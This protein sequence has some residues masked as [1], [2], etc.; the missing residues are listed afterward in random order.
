M[1][2]NN[3]KK[4]AGITLW[5]VA[6]AGF[7]LVIAAMLTVKVLPTVTEF[8]KVK[9]NIH[10]TINKEGPN[11]SKKDLMRTY[12]KFA[13][14]DM[15]AID[16]SKLRFKKTGG[17]WDITADYEKRIHLF[18]NAYLV[19]DYYASTGNAPRVARGDRTISQIE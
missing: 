17:K 10:A 15:L 14:V 6:I 9:K 2:C 11:A 3:L 19:L 16:S 7:F 5:G 1:Q 4:Q 12:D 13:D 8:Y 18:W